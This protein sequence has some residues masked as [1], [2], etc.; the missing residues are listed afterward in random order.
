MQTEAIA[1][2]DLRAP[3]RNVRR[4]PEAQIKELCRAV[5]MFG[6]TRPIVIDE[7]NAVLAGNGLVEAFRRLKYTEI[8]AYR[9]AGLTHEQKQKLMLS[10]NK[11]FTLGVDDYEA[12]QD[13]LHS[14]SDLDVPGFDEQFLRDLTADIDRL[15]TEH[16]ATF[17]RVS[18]A[19]AEVARGRAMPDGSR[20][21]YQ[22]EERQVIVCPRCGE[23]IY[24]DAH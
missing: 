15:T 17:G 21:E 22:E 19:E 11:I 12:I 18:E 1:L 20:D 2:D 16:T 9:L 7:D 5:R 24:P 3:P 10:D 8:Q 6:Q 13:M 4:H 23:A 14:I